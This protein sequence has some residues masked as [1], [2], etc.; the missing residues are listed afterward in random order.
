[1]GQHVSATASIKC[2]CGDAPTPLLVVD[3]R[4]TNET[5]MAANIQDYIPFVNI[6]PFGT[7]KVLTTAAGG[8]PT[9]CVPATVA[10]WAPGSP[11]VLVRGAPALNNSSKC[12]CTVGGMISVVTSG[13]TKEM[14][15]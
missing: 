8:T 6:N 13:S 4:V 15:P 1:M 11:T 14:V 9:P 7:C 3:P 5:L 10:P 2:T 12:V